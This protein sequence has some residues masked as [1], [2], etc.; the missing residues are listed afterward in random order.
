[1]N[2]F[3]AALDSIG[4]GVLDTQVNNITKSWIDDKH[5][6]PANQADMVT[7]LKLLVGVFFSI[8]AQGQNT[9]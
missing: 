5:L 7:G 3:D 8:L 1:M 9:K 2:I 4:E 6:D